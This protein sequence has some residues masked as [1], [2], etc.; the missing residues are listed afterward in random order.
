MRSVSHTLDRLA[1]DF[2]DDRLVGDAGLI[3]PATLG[4]HLGLR[5][6]F[7]EHVDLGDAPGRANVGHK[8]MTVVHAVL[9][10]ADS[11]DDCDMLRAAS[12]AAVLG[13]AVLAPSTIGVFLRSFTWGHARQLDRVAAQVLARAWN[14]G[15]GPGDG[16]VTIDIDSSIVETFGLAKAGGSRFSYAYVRGYHPL[17]A[18]IAATGDVV[19][20]RLRGGPAHSARGAASF[21]A[22]T[23]SRVRAAGATGPLVARA[24]SGFYNHNVVAA[25]RKAGAAYSLTT[26][27]SKPLRDAIAKIP[28]QNWTAIPYFLADGA[29]VAEVDYQAFAKSKNAPGGV[30]TR[31]IVRRVRPTPGSQLALFVTWSYHA[32]ITNR[33]GTVAALEADHRRHAVVEN[34]IRDLKY[35]V[36]LNHLPS[37]R[38][39]ANAA[40]L[41]L[42]VIAH[43]I[44]AWTARLGALD[45]NTDTAADPP[46][47]DEPARQARARRSFV[48]TDTLRRRY[49]HIPGRVTT[50]GR[51]RTLHLPTNWP[52]RH[53]FDQ[54]LAKLR[55]VTLTT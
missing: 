37:G 41:T 26:K 33:T 44:A 34:T 28:D 35:G 19:H 10:G 54:T 32:F 52:W 31:L 2:D 43:N 39:G 55:T 42:N 30:K 27:M 16:P 7:D 48:A 53:A 15:A 24:D 5:E 21:L 36:G 49:L 23:F 45:T 12:S 38:F 8:A 18:T 13:H 29:D 22:E 14:G 25:C 50:T 11:I 6:L 1:V 20:S 3:L 4:Q 51:R 47:V 40:W 46:D 17:F 9:G